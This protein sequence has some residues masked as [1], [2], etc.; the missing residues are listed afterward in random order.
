M[1]TR[2]DHSH[3]FSTTSPDEFLEH[4]KFAGTCDFS[5]SAP[6]IDPIKLAF[7]AILLASFKQWQRHTGFDSE[8]IQSVQQALRFQKLREEL[9]AVLFNQ[10]QPT[11]SQLETT[12]RLLFQVAYVRQLLVSNTKE[13]AMN[14]PS[15]HL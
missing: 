14:C 9:T 3:D 7:V 5:T 11:D 8:V 1:N 10:G 6:N 13:K 4:F 12:F 15:S 2:S